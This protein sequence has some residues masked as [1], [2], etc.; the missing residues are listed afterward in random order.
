MSQVRHILFRGMDI[1]LIVPAFVLC[2]QFSDE[3]SL[4]AGLSGAVPQALCFAVLLMLSILAKDKALSRLVR[5]FGFRSETFAFPG[6]EMDSRKP[7]KDIRTVEVGQLLGRDPVVLD[8]RGISDYLCG[9][10]VLVSGAA[11]SIGSELC[12]QVARFGPERL[13][14]LDHAETPLFHIHREL[15]AAHPGLALEAVIGDVKNASKVHAVFADFR[16]D[17]VFHSAAYKHVP[18]MECNQAEA[19]ANNVGGTAVMADA[20]DRFG[21]ADFVMISTD[22]AVNPVS[23]MGASKRVAEVYVQALAGKS[24]TRFTTVRFGNVLGSNGSVI[25]IFMEQ[26]R[27]GGPV[28]VTDPDMTR[29]FMTIPEA[30]QLVLQAGCLGKGG[31]IFVLDMGEPVRIIDLAEKLIRLSGFV[32]G[33]DMEIVFTGARPGEKL[34]EELLAVGE[35]VVPTIH[36]KISVVAPA[37]TDFET[38]RTELQRLLRLAEFNDLPGLLRALRTFAPGLHVVRTGTDHMTACP[39]IPR[40]AE[41]ETAWQLCGM[42]SVVD[43]MRATSM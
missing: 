28:T 5:R 10:R 25:P 35:G 4:H 36:E 27:S 14:L 32:P 29:Y 37:A 6:D 21:V 17:V 40:I 13:I 8:H 16:P 2:R 23:V 15:S 1:I 42:T 33:L 19:V 39:D 11:G 31:E 20:A 41:P 7:G 12:R 43:R 30:S 26:I 38:V 24:S 18:M 34:Y 3:L 9:R 22:K